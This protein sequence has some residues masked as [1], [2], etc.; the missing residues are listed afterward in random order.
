RLGIYQMQDVALLNMTLQDTSPERASDVLSNLIEVY[1]QESLNDK[2]KVAAI[3][4]DFI[5]E[6]LK[7][8]EEDLGSVEEKLEGIKRSNYGLD[9]SAAGQQYWSESREYMSTS[10]D[11]ETTKKLVE[12]IRD[13][14]L[15]SEK[16][17]LIPSNTGLLDGNIES[18]ISSYNSLL[19]KRNSY[20]EDNSASNPIVEDLNA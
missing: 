11:I 19:L 4:A 14:L 1:N 15:S 20:L 13:R 6:R 17:E 9:I 16:D 18:Q 10:K 12:A 7:I 5:K 3:T 2:N 8:I